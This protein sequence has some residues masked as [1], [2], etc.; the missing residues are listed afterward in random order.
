MSF[1]TQQLRVLEKVSSG[2]PTD[3]VLSDIVALVDGQAEHILC[4]LFTLDA[5]GQRLERGYSQRIPDEYTSSL[6]GLAIGPNIGSCGAA[7]FHKREVVAEEIA[8][9]PN[10]IPYRENALAYELKSCWSTPILST[11]GRVLGTFAI[12]YRS[13]RHPEP[14]ER[15]WVSR[16][17]HLAAIAIERERSQQRLL[18]SQAKAEQRARLYAVSSKINA[19]L[20]ELV[21]PQEKCDA[22]CQYLVEGGLVSLAAMGQYDEAGQAFRVVSSFGRHKDY[23]TVTQLPFVD[24][25]MSEHPLLSVRDTGRPSVS[26]DLSATPSVYWKKQALGRSLLSMAVFPIDVSPDTGGAILLCC[27]RPHLFKDEE[28]TILTGV[29]ESISRSLQSARWQRERAKLVGDLGERVKELTALHQL[30]RVL[31]TGNEESMLPEIGEILP[32]GFSFPDKTVVRIT[33]G[34]RTWES[35]KWRRDRWT[36]R[37]NFPNGLIEVSTLESPDNTDPFLKEERELLESIAEMIG[38][39]SQQRAAEEKLKERESLLRIAGRAARIGGWSMSAPDFQPIWSEEIYSLHEVATDYTPS[40]EKNLEFISTDYRDQLRL[41]IAD[42]IEHG[43]AFDL[44]AQLIT[45][46]RKIRWVRVIGLAERDA[47]GKVTRVQ[48]A[49]QDISEQRKLEEELRKNQKLEAVG[50]L[51]GGVAHDFNNLLTV[52]LSYSSLAMDSIEPDDPLRDDLSEIVEA[53]N[54]ASELTRQLLAFSRK[55]LLAPRLLNLN[56]VAGG[57]QKML[58]QLVGDQVRLQWHL[59]EGLLPILADPTQMEQVLMNLLVNSRDAIEKEG[60]VTIETLNVDRLPEEIVG[61]ERS[62]GFVRLSVTDDGAGIP[63]ELRSRIFDPF[64][65]TKFTG[66]GTGLGLATVWGIVKQSGGH[67]LVDSRLGVGTTFQIFFPAS[68]D[69]LE[70]PE[71]PKDSA[72]LGGSESVLLVEDN[73]QVRSAIHN[74]LRNRGYTVVE[75]ENA[76][77]ALLLFEKTPG[78]IDLLLTDVVMPV[79]NGRELADKI[80]A[81]QADIKVLYLSGYPES[82]LGEDRILDPDV[83]FLAKPVTPQSLLKKVREVLES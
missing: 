10:W 52:I 78:R 82:V 45:Q 68:E 17:T 81:I 18:R 50:R 75:A 7:A 69:G 71:K 16:A 56:Q 12:Y 22:A 8:N 42:C 40:L 21:E 41:A 5:A 54:K 25:R 3:E 72:T 70:E 80:K 79:M 11:D 43:T 57:V 32:G 62:E 39:T 24:Q 37:K 27:E 55:Q 2:R 34:T 58:K 31:H 29:A 60:T 53:G 38:R 35:P 14:I 19:A 33:W 26:N 20:L 64:F 65:T 13:P 28:I 76:G 15:N 46:Q 44:E 73:S 61:E 48:G 67:I 23:L 47:G 49:V 63:D 74:I 4:S 59:S 77:E 30:S 83:S 9:H 66:K 36:L 51:A 6:V 1:E